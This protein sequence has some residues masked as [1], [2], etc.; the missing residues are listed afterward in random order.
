MDS[1]TPLQTV[2]L[3]SRV[4]AKKANA[5]LDKMAVNSVMGSLLLGFGCAMNVLTLSSPWFQQN[6][7]GLIRSISASFFPVGLIMVFLTGADLFTSY[8]MVSG[9]PR[10][11]L[12]G[13]YN[14]NIC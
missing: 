7:P 10:S 5:R 13:T 11:S 12:S 3:L 4:G 1:F 14:A 6:A 2:E 9:T 8:C